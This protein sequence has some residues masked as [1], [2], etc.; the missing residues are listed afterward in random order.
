MKLNKFYEFVQSDF[1]A[2]KSFHL[3]DDLNDTQLIYIN[4]ILKKKN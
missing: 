2:I 1:E 4:Q 3:K